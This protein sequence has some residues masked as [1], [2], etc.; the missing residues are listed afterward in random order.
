MLD[1]DINMVEH[2]HISAQE[3]C[4]LKFTKFPFEVSSEL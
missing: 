2:V 4:K 3:I 1:M